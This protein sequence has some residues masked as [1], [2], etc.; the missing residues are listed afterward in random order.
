MLL[1]VK[2]ITKNRLLHCIQNMKPKHIRETLHL[3]PVDS[4]VSISF[5][6]IF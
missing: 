6:P 4:V 5:S 1:P 3:S 2:W